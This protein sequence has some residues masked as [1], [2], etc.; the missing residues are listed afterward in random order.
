MLGIALHADHQVDARLGRR[1]SAGRMQRRPVFAQLQHL[2]GH[3]NAASAAGRAASVRI[4]E[5]SASGFEL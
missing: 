2:A 5:R 4:I 3:Q 1:T